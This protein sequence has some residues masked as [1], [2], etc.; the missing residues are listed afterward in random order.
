VLDESTADRYTVYLCLG[1]MAQIRIQGVAEL[2][3]LGE[4]LALD[5]SAEGRTSLKRQSRR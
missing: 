2:A 5:G 1:H 4:L 3:A